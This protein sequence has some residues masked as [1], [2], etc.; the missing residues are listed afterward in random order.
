MK[1]FIKSIIFVF[2]FLIFL[3]PLSYILRPDSDMKRRFTGYYA[4]PD[5]AIDVVMIGSSPVH[6]YYAAPLAWNKYGFTSFTLATNVQQPKACMY[7]LKE[8]LKTQKPEVVIFELRMFSRNQEDFDKDEQYEAFVRNVTDNM[9][10]S[11]NRFNA[12]NTLA[13]QDQRPAYYFDIIKYHNNWKQKISTIDNIRYWDFENLDNLK[14]HLIVG[15]VVNLSD[16]SVDYSSI[17]EELPMPEEQEVHLRNVLEYCKSNK[18]N[19]LFVVNPYTDINE[20]AQK[21]FNYMDNIITKEYGYSFINFNNLYKDMKIDFSKDYYN[22]GHM[23]IYGAEIYT[24]YLA[25]YLVKN[26]DL[27]DKRGNEKYQSW[28]NAYITWRLKA[29]EAEEAIDYLMK[30]GKQ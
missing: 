3:V 8:A 13:P 16:K 14:G 17:T 24:E 21:I 20:D 30:G 12:I 26:Y 23:N 7:L 4:E 10:Y 2:I 15:D 19:G 28:D 18:I 6:P 1:N 5:N 22:G 9:K 29:D 11:L 27:H 25:D